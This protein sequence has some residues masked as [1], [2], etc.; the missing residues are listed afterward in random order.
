[1]TSSESHKSGPAIFPPSAFLHGPLSR[2]GS[3][4]LLLRAERS[5]VVSWAL[6]H[7]TND[8]NIVVADEPADVSIVLSD[9]NNES[10]GT[11]RLAALGSERGGAV[12]LVRN[13]TRSGSLVLSL[14]HAGETHHYEIL[15]S[16]SLLPLP[17]SVFCYTVTLISYLW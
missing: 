14:R 6:P 8:S 11:S 7:H 9:D 3:N 2:E 1:M 16:V 5:S 10:I 12:F 13:S 17:K 15:Q 4:E